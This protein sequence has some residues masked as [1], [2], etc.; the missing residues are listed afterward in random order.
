[1]KKIWRILYQP[2][3]WLILTP[4]YVVSTIFFGGLAVV[5]CMFLDPRVP[6]YLCGADRK[7]VV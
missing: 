2:Y 6:S 7:S 1:M 3:K 4:V 5:L